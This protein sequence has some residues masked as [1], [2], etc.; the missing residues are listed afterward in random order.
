MKISIAEAAKK[1]RMSKRQMS[2]LIAG[3]SDPRYSTLRKISEALHL[4]VNIRP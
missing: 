4:G 1:A 3:E 2:R